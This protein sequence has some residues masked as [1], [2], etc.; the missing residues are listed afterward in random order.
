MTP[1]FCQLQNHHSDFDTYQSSQRRQQI[2]RSLA[3]LDGD[4]LPYDT[5]PAEKEELATCQTVTKNIVQRV[6]YHVS[7]SRI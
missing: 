2:H 1:W 5:A 3:V 7:C 4:G 6:N